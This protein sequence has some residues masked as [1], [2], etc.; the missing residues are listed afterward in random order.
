MK[1]GKLQPN[2]ALA[3]KIKSLRLA[4]VPKMSQERLAEE[5]DIDVTTLR[6]YESGKNGIPKSMLERMAEK[7]NCSPDCLY[8]IAMDTVALEEQKPVSEME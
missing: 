4:L 5:L 1:K 3:A 6:N 8:K 2:P 7:L